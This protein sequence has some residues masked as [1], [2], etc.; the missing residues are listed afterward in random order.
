MFYFIVGF[1]E[2]NIHRCRR[3]VSSLRYENNRANCNALQLAQKL[4]PQELLYIGRL[5]DVDH[6]LSSNF[7]PRLES[8]GGF[9]DCVKS[10]RGHTYISPVIDPV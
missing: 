9:P 7:K 6:L 1:R 2:I 8:H 3:S 4:C 5:H 10:Y